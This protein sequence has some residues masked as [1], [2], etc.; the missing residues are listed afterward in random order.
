MVGGDCFA[1]GGGARRGVDPGGGGLRPKSTAV[2]SPLQVHPWKRRPLTLHQYVHRC[3][4]THA[5]VVDAA[6]T[7]LD[8]DTRDTEKELDKVTR[9]VTIWARS[10]ETKATSYGNA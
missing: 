7:R 8:R 3:V 6:R 9:P 1:P 5:G 4:V 10:V 2:P